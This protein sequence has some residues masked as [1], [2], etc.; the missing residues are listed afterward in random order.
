MLCGS[1]SLPVQHW[2]PVSGSEISVLDH[3]FVRL[4]D[5]MA[6]DLS[7]VNSAR[8]SFAARSEYEKHIVGIESRKEP[9]NLETLRTEGVEVEYR[10]SKKDAGLIS[11]LMKNRHGTP[12]EH[13]SFRFHVKAP[14]FVFREWQRHRISSYNEWSA[15]YSKLEPEFYIPDNVRSQVGKPGAYSFEPV[16]EE[17]A[18]VF[19]THLKVNAEH[20]F[21]RYE[22]A[23]SMGIAKEQARMFLPVNIYSQ[24]Y[25]TVNARSLMNFLS[26]RNSDQAM[27]EIRE[28]ARVVEN[29]F[30]QK[31]PVTA[32]A[33][34]QNDRVA[35]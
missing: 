33:F 23:M 7:V 6:D 32:E 16:D 34:V 21:H 11:F 30:K 24:M 5:S 1:G 19:R 15:R 4:D 18:R 31:M 17:K 35:P 13:N 8:V 25:W 10:L 22:F 12:F 28:Y 27:W 2:S 20:A 9:T 29:I 3:G 26:L 14:L